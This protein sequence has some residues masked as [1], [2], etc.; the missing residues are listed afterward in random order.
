MSTELPANP[1]L[2]Y[3]KKQAKA[4]L[5]DFRQKD[6]QAIQKFSTLQLK[7]TPKLSDA[8]RLV[9]R[10]YDF[11]SWSKLKKHVDSVNAATAQAVQLAKKAVRD[12]DA[13]AFRRA[14]EQHPLLKAKINDPLG[15]F[16]SPLVNQ[17]RSAAM[18][19]VLLD[20]GADINAR[21]QW[22]AGGFGRS[23]APS[24][25]WPHTLSSAAPSS[26]SM[27]QRDWA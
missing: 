25:H 15:D 10:E 19:D 7:A 14:L 9:A 18:L 21:S 4:L 26:L 20:A 27:R 1:D 13:P 8:Q 22:W 2:E 12:D 16:D 23:M 24:R 11:D 3:L 5:Q 6:P 17:V